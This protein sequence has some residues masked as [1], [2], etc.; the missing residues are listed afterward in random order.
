MATIFGA[1]Q[2]ALIVTFVIAYIVITTMLSIWTMKFTKSNEH[3]MTAGGQLP[4]W[5]IGL[6]MISEYIGTSATV[7]T[8]QA[9][10]DNGI[11]A[12]WSIVTFVI[13]FPLF[14]WFI[15]P[16]FY[17]MREYTISG[18]LNRQYGKS[19]RV[20]TSVIMIYALLVV[21]VANYV[22]GA[23]AVSSV[24]K[25]SLP[26]AALITAGVTIVYV[27]VGGLR[28]VAYVN[29]IHF[30]FKYLAVI[31]VVIVGVGL[32]ASYSNMLAKLPEVY[33]TSVGKIGLPTIIA[34][35][36]ANLGA[37]F[38]TQMTIQAVASVKSVSDARKASLIAGL[39]AVPMGILATYIGLQSKY[40]FP[41][42]KSV[43]ALPIF[44]HHMNPWL[45]S[46]VTAGIVATVFANVS[47]TSLAITALAMKDFIV[48][49]AKPSEEGKLRISR[50]VSIFIGLLPL[51]FVLL[52]PTII[53]TMFFAKALRTSLSVVAVMGFY[54]PFFKSDRGATWGLIIAAVG[55]SVWYFSGEP[56]HI[57][58]TYVAIALPVIIL[59]L[60]RL[61][62]R[63]K[64]TESEKDMKA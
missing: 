62:S 15:A 34:W 16:K 20:M 23:A 11:A 31:I 29:L 43:M 10:F 50:I 19:T 53:K 4:F 57:D 48:P 41:T 51:P 8:A 61:L 49:L 1:S 37:V 32:G 45:G 27:A 42:I 36:L 47:A 3:F 56:F 22:G 35:G 12:A 46:I 44:I 40:L 60:D 5:I 13:V 25:V 28:S 6:L 24:L 64:Y 30:A 38:S 59:I 14:G 39:L 7:G 18:V 21:N 9:S 54:L 55:A 58:S 2:I 17:E 52:V 63:R 33:F 26:V